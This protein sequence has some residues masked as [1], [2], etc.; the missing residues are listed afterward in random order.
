LLSDNQNQGVLAREADGRRN[1]FVKDKKLAQHSLPFVLGRSFS[2]KTAIYDQKVPFPVVLQELN[3]RLTICQGPV[4]ADDLNRDRDLRKFR[5]TAAGPMRERSS[6]RTCSDAAL[7]RIS[8]SRS[9][10]SVPPIL[11]LE[12]NRCPLPRMID[13][14][15]PPTAAMPNESWGHSFGMRA[16]W[17][18]KRGIGTVMARPGCGHAE[19]VQKGF[20]QAPCCRLLTCSDGGTAEAES[21]TAKSLHGW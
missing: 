20:L 1:C 17:C 13:V 16:G 4:P 19:Q 14:G 9:R 21:L 8:M 6:D 12:E 10:P 5:A 18:R 3:R 11:V 15:D 7:S 2:G